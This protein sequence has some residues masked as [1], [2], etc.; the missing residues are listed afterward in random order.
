MYAY[1]IFPV[2]PKSGVVKVMIPITAKGTAKN[3]M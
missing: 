1:I 2:Y 3:K